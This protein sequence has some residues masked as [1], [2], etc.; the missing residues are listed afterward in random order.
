METQS[1]GTVAPEAPAKK[2]SP[3]GIILA[4]LLVLI[5]AGTA[6]SLWSQGNNLDAELAAADAQLAKLEGQYAQLQSDQEKLKGDNEKLTSELD[7]AKT[8]LETASGEL[9]KT[10]DSL[11]EEQGKAET[12][13]ANIDDTSKL[14]DVVIALFVYDANEDGVGEKVKATGNTELIELW[15]DFMTKKDGESADAFVIRLFEIIAENLDK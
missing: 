14:M 6:F 7:Q 5:L 13:Q 8:D 12:V 1:Q 15:D 10:Q 4:V 2:K 3:I 11:T 9:T